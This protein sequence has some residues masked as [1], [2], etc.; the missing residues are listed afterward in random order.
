M[1]SLE[2]ILSIT[3]LLEQFIIYSTAT[4]IDCHFDGELIA[5]ESKVFQ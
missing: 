4:D 2:R 5:G 1:K 3:A